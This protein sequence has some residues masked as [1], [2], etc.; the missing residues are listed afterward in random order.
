LSAVKTFRTPDTAC[1]CCG[2][3]LTGAADTDNSGRAPHV[4]E[5]AVCIFCASLLQYQPGGTLR[6]VTTAEIAA[7]PPEDRGI[8][9]RTQRAVRAV[10][11][12]SGLMPDEPEAKA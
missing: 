11:A 3:L 4:G 7:M 1:P 10:V 9:E 12:M 5:M 8:V 6:A 2:G